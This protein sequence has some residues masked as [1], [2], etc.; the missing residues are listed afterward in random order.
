MDRKLH[1]DTL[2]LI[3]KLIIYVFWY[4]IQTDRQMDRDI[5][6][7]HVGWRNLSKTAEKEF[8]QPRRSECVRLFLLNPNFLLARSNRHSKGMD[9][10]Q[11]TPRGYPNFN[12]Y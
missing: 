1:V 7:L 10:G 2:I 4:S 12:S 6:L 5:H 8:L 9:D 3:P 11:I